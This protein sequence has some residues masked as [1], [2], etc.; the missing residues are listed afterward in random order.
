[1]G[2]VAHEVNSQVCL[3]VGQGGLVV[4]IIADWGKA[5]AVVMVG[6]ARSPRLGDSFRFQGRDWVI[7]RARDHART[8][9]AR[10]VRR[11]R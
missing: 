4:P 8:Y 6:F 3:Q 11:R 9:V 10:P 1:M 7:T 2:S 5:A